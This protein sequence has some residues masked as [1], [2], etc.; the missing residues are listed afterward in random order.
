LRSRDATTASK[1]LVQVGPEPAIYGRWLALS[2]GHLNGGYANVPDLRAP[3]VPVASSALWKAFHKPEG[4][5]ELA[6]TGT[7]NWSCFERF[8]ASSMRNSLF[9]IRDLISYS[10]FSATAG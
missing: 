7:G 5:R 8:T 9:D 1:V 6:S 10:H 3:T 4:L 2:R